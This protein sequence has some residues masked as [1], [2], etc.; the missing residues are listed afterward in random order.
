ML[1]RYKRLLDRIGAIEQALGIG[2]I[3]LIVVA[4]TVQVFTRYALGRPIAWVEESAT[5]AFIWMVFV[6]ASLGLK[7][8]RHIF[9][10]TFA[11][12]LGARAAAGL[13]ALVSLL[14]LL[15][16]AVLVQQGIKVMGVEGRSSTISLP[17]ELPRSW[18]YSLPLTLSAASMALTTLWL[19]LSDL[20]LLRGGARASATASQQVH[21][22]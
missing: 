3:L 21:G 17:I 11:S 5:Y 13:R 10:A 14:M 22:A 8:G 4:I 15:T 1:A 2:L 20:V 12:R 7:K 16:L 19:L 18:F 9:I 6:G